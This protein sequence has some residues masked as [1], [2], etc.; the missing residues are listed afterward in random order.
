MPKSLA[1]GPEDNIYV[2]GYSFGEKTS[3]DYV[4]VKYDSEGNQLWVVRYPDLKN[5]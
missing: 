3:Y 1:V 5:K 4:T 2:T